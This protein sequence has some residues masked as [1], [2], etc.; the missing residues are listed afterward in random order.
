MVHVKIPAAFRKHTN[1]K[2]DFVVEAASLLE[3]LEAL[4]DKYPDVKQH[5]LS[6]DGQIRRFI[7]IYV[8]KDDIRLLKGIDTDLNTGDS[9]RI[10][11]AIAGG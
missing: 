1:H 10:V 5:V 7:N 11:P 6:P 9:I 8:N 2:P 4:F 3:A